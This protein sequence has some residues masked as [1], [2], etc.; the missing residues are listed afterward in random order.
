MRHSVPP[1]RGSLSWRCPL[2][3]GRDRRKEGVG[4][5]REAGDGGAVR[6]GT[7]GLGGRRPARL[8]FLIFLL[9]Q[10]GRRR[11]GQGRG[12]KSVFSPGP[13]GEELPPAPRPAATST[14]TPEII[15]TPSPGKKIS[16]GGGKPSAC[17]LCS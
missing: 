5:V 17:F 2:R 8:W 6:G 3:G 10:D 11:R 12:E 15:N 4:G 1:L 16:G 14:I 7:H 9:K 13:S